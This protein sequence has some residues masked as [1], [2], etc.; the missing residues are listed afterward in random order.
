[1]H[2]PPTDLH[3]T[4]HRSPRTSRRRTGALALVVCGAVTATAAAGAR[5]HAV[6][7]VGA[8][9]V[10][11]V[12]PQG[13]HSLPGTRVSVPTDPVP[14]ITVASGP[15][16]WGRGC[17]ELDLVFPRTAVAI[18]VVEWVRTTPGARFV[19][20]PQRFT[21][22]NLPVRRPPAVECFRGPAGGTQF[23]QRGRRFAAY[24]LLGMDAP[25]AL[26]SRA[27]G[28]LDTLAVTRTG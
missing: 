5:A 11:V 25:T 18:V 17:N 9:G 14:R 12:V 15:V 1:V 26:V 19:P 4:H 2:T 27:R 23:S 6:A 28:V 3:G 8:R 20:R 10:T 21:P 13:W 16:R 24:L 7:R 22:A